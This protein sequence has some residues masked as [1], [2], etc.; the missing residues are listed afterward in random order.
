MKMEAPGFSETLVII[1]QITQRHILE[2]SS[3]HSYR[4]KDLK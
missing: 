2:D 3:S 1:H 4:N